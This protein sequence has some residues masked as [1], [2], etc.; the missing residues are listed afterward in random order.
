MKVFL[1]ECIDW[2]LSRDLA[3]H[4]MTARQMGWTS[5]TNGELLALASRNSTC[6]SR[7][8]A[9]FHSSRIWTCCRLP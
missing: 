4:E 7:S 2:R 6:S 9:T 5:I 8:T 1:D 3:D